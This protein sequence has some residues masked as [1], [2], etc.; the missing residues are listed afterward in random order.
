MNVVFLDRD[1]TVIAE[2]DDRRVDNTNKIELFDDS[3]AALKYLADNDFA[4][5]LITNQA[6]IEEGRLTEEE[7]W[8]I[9]NEVLI[10]LAPSGV[11]ILKTYMNGEMAR[12]DNTEWR[13]P[14]PK[15]LLQAAS[16]FNVDIS[17]IYM[18]GDSES[19]IQAALNAGCR[20]GILLKTTDKH[21]SSSDAVYTASTLTDAVRHIVSTTL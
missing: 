17:N 4:V 16:E 14:G 21:A 2:P 12:S 10:Q 3:I 15:M 5:V 9:H 19:D 20:G 13:K 11:K 7:F 1:G 8:S 18:V 6:G